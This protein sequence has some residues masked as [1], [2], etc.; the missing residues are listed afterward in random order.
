VGGDTVYLT[1]TTGRIRPSTV[2]VPLQKIQ[3]VRWSQGPVS[4][5]LRLASVA[6][7]TAG[8][9]F[10]AEAKFRDEGEAHA[11]LWSLPDQ[12]RAARRTRAP[13]LPQR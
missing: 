8:Q 10:T 12:A 13:T 6:V 5:R 9:R 11:M 2:V 3:S 4:R 1:C 7:D